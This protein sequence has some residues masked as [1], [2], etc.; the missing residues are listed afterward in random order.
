VWLSGDPLNDRLLEFE[1]AAPPDETLVSVFF[2]FNQIAYL[3]DPAQ[4]A[5]LARGLGA[6][7]KP[8]KPAE[9]PDQ[10]ARIGQRDER[11]SKMSPK[12]KR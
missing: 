12:P 11:P 1:D 8:I 9:T 2:P 3:F 4:F 6:R 5:Y 7:A 10:P